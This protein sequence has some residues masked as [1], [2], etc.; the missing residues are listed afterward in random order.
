MKAR[1]MALRSR[2]LLPVLSLALCTTVLGSASAHTF[3][4]T[5]NQGSVSITGDMF[6]QGMQAQSG[7]WAGEFYSQGM[8]MPFGYIYTQGMTIT[9]GSDP[10]NSDVGDDHGSF[11][12]GPTHESGGYDDIRPGS[13]ITDDTGSPTNHGS[14]DSPPIFGTTTVSFDLPPGNGPGNVLFSALTNSSGDGGNGGGNPAP[15]DGDGKPGWGNDGNPGNPAPGNIIAYFDSPPHGGDGKP[16][17]G[18]FGHHD[19]PSTDHHHVDP[20]PEPTSL[21]LLGSAF[22]GFLLLWAVSL[23][24]RSPRVA[25]IIQPWLRRPLR[26]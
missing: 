10:S 26:W 3:S 16:G 4:E 5:I 21:N 25:V 2:C 20:V 22:L 15:H 12:G 19:Q 1:Y 7:P 23:P 17:G 11:A 24:C 14:H 6:S 18:D 8:M 13:T 9:F